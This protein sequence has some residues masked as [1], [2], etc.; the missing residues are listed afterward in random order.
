MSYAAQQP[1]VAEPPRR[2]LPVV[3]ASVLL[4]AMGVIGL[5]YAVA[6]LAVTPTVIDRFRGASGSAAA[7]DVDPLVTVVWVGAGIG[8]AV[9]VLLFVLYLL[10]ALGLRR[11]SNAARIGVWVLSGL[12][13]LAGCAATVAVLAQRSGDGT[14][15]S[16]GAT[17]SDAYPGGWIGGN[18][19]LAIGQMLGYLVVAILLLVSPGTFF[20]RRAPASGTYAA[21]AP[22]GSRTAPGGHAP[23]PS[24]NAAPPYGPGFSW[25]PPGAYP[26]AG[27]GPGAPGAYRPGPFGPPSSG[28]A[29]S[30]SEASPYARPAGPGAAS[31]S[32]RP[33]DAAAPTGYDASRVPVAG[34]GHRPVDRRA[35]PP[36]GGHVPSKQDEQYWSRPAD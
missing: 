28:P 2:P 17:L 24:A 31:G 14:P 34:T 30:P 29:G 27:P 15:G 32:D 33:S 35:A 36:P 5:A 20:R 13:L 23:G 10:L 26:P 25:T 4:T 1:A 19:A 6:T 16:L 18:L 8:A 12:G 3:L 21:I 9:A 22:Y 11:G 7:A